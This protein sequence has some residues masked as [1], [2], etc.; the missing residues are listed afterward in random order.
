MNNP[1]TISVPDDLIV[2]ETNVE[3]APDGNAFA[4]LA[5]VERGLRTAGNPPSVID[6]YRRQATAGDYDFLLRVSLA[7]TGATV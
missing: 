2:P 6:E 3:D 7:F 5:T 1:E 4:I